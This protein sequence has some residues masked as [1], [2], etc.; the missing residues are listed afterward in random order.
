MER[1]NCGAIMTK[2]RAEL[3]KSYLREHNIYFE[4]SELGDSVHFSCKM[5]EEELNQANKW[6]EANLGE[7]L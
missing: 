2:T 1:V 6:I 5:T 3:F 7:Q 4:P